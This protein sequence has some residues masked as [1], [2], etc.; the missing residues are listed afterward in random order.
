MLNQQEGLFENSSWLDVKDSNEVLHELQIQKTIN[1][2]PKN[3][4]F[5]YR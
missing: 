3:E 1:P 2:K 5:S 4:L